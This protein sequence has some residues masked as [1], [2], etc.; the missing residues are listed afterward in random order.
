[1]SGEYL[2]IISTSAFVTTWTVNFDFIS[3]V[4]FKLSN[5]SVFHS[6]WCC[7][8]NSEQFYDIFA[9]DNISAVVHAK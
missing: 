4:S 6:D 5:V 1:M 8:K 7:D 9:I 3:G 2:F